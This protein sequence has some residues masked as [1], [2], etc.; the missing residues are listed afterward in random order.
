MR[1]RLFKV[2]TL[3]KDLLPDV[4]DG[5]DL[6][7]KKSLMK[8]SFTWFLGENQLIYNDGLDVNVHSS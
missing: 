7:H 8:Y 2:L 6:T 1:K 4:I 5:D 3:V